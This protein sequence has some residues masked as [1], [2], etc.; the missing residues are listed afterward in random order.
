M[1]LVKR[2][3]SHPLLLDVVNR[4]ALSHFGSF[5]DVSDFGIGLKRWVTIIGDHDLGHLIPRSSTVLYQSLALNSYKV[6]FIFFFF[7]IVLIMLKTVL[8]STFFLD[9]IMSVV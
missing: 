7:D 9:Q 2:S 6:L 4:K 1:D 8:T 5:W 3:G